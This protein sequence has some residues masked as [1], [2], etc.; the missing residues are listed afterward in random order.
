M[1]S[2]KAAVRGRGSLVASSPVRNDRLILRR[3]TRDFE[4]SGPTSAGGASEDIVG[5]G[6]GMSCYGLV[7]LAA[8]IYLTRRPNMSV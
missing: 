2:G 7:R 1:R 6:L 5:I 4:V 3:F 8:P